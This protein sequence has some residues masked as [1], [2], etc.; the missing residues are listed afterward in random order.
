M[1]SVI[2]RN[3]VV[4]HMTEDTGNSGLFLFSLML[5]YV[6]GCIFENNDIV[7]FITSYVLHIMDML[8]LKHC[9]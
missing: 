9:L 2:D 5:F 4:Q 6:I 7:S 3:V 8:F 1:R